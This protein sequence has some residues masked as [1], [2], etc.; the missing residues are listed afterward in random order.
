MGLGSRYSGEKEIYKRHGDRSIGPYR[1]VRMIWREVN[2]C[3]TDSC[4]TGNDG[5]AKGRP[6]T[7]KQK[8]VDQFIIKKNR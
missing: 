3:G 4:E 7:L 1:G 2:S 6:V 5:K 8:M